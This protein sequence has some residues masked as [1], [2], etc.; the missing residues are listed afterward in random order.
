MFISF[1]WGVFG[2]GGFVQGVFVQ[3]FCLGGFCL[4]FYVWGVFVRGFFV[5]IPIEIGN[6]SSPFSSVSIGQATVNWAKFSYQ[7]VEMFLCLT[8]KQNF[9]CCQTNFAHQT[10][11]VRKFAVGK[12]SN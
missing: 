10:Q 6:I 2:K 9:A 8:R 4:G 5:L 7:K 3:G 1:L 12:M 11:N